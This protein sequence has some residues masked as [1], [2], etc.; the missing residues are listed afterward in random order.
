MF[1]YSSRSF[2]NKNGAL[3]TVINMI[4]PVP[5]YL[6]EVASKQVV[7]DVYVSSFDVTKGKG[8]GKGMGKGKGKGK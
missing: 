1:F 8:K 2:T 3:M 6:F 7:V 5:R 4:V